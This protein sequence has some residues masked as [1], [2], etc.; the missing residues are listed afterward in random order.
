MFDGVGDGVEQFNTVVIPRSS[1]KW[2]GVE[3]KGSIFQD[4]FGSFAWPGELSAT[5]EYAARTFQVPLARS[6]RRDRHTELGA[7]IQQART[8]LLA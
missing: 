7:L 6:H 1:L 8:D 5:F 2:L 4:T 3:A